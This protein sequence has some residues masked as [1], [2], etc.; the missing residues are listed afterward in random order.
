M[1][2]FL[3]ILAFAL[4]GHSVLPA[5]DANPYAELFWRQM[6]GSCQG[7]LEWEKSVTELGEEATHGK[8][9]QTYQ[10]DC[11][12][13]TLKRADATGENTP[14]LS[15]F[16]FLFEYDC[17][18]PYYVEYYEVVKD[19]E[20]LSAVLKEGNEGETPLQQQSFEVDAAGKLRFAE[21]H[22]VKDTRL[23]DMDVHIKVWFDAAGHYERHET[24]TMTQPILKGPV[25]TL[26]EGKVIR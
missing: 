26:I 8:E 10:I 7:V 12:T 9:T 4:I 1:K 21:S 15:E 25:R 22:I 16:D 23:Y 24:L 14:G 13:G 3:S 20:S 6:Q 19:G 11:S 2:T 5:Q 18:N 17:Q